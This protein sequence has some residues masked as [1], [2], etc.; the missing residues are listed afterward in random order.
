MSGDRGIKVILLGESGVGKTNIILRYVKNK[1]IKENVSTIGSSFIKKEIKRNNKIYNLNIWDT[2]GQ[3]KYR[4]VTKL[5]IQ[6]ASIIMLVYSIDDLESF[7]SLEFWY[8]H[9]IDVCNDYVFAIV[10][11]KYDLFIDEENQKVSDEEAKKFAE[12]KNAIFKLVSAKEDKKGI[13]CL[14]E[15]MFDEYL[16]KNNIN[17]NYNDNNNSID[18][19]NNAT[20][21]KKNKKCC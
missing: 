8:N 14:F 10:G 15:Q 1:F 18:I 5:F 11:N 16:K 7:K 6:G 13:D 19:E 4:S 9:F 3:E 2:S 20:K 17:E 21:T 12:E